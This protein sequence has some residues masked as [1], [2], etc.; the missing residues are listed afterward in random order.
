[1]QY[2]IRTLDELSVWNDPNFDPSKQKIPAD[3]LS[4]LKSKNNTL[5]VFIIDDLKN[6]DMIIL[7]WAINREEVRDVFCQ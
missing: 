7:S 4:Q 5:S 2:V 3:P 1:M 6:L